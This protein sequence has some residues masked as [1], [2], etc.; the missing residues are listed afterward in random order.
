MRL[1][2][3]TTCL[4]LA[5]GATAFSATIVVNTGQYESALQAG[6]SEAQVDWRDA[7]QADDTICTEAFAATELQQY[8]RKMTGGAGDFAIVDDL[9][10]PEGDVIVVGSPDSNALM[11][12]IAPSLGVSASALKQLGPEGY[13]IK[14]AMQGG[15]RVVLIA[16]GARVG[17]LYGAY[18]FL[19]SLGVRWYAPGEVNEEVPSWRSDTFPNLDI[20]ESP[21]FLT[22]G[23]H[24]WEN[25]G[26]EQFVLWM[27]R[28]RLNYWCVQQDNKP[29]LH[30][31]G[32][33]LVGG[34]HVLTSFYLPPQGEYPYNH[35]K[36]DGD[37]AKPDDP[38]PVSPEYQGDADK[39]GKLTYFEAHPEWFGLREGKRSDRIRGDGGDNFCTSNEDAMAE[40]MKGAVDD[41]AEGRYADADIMN[42]WTLDGGRWCQCE[43]CKALGSQT[44]RNLLFVHAY[45]KAIKRAQAE[46]RINRPVRLLF[47]AYADVLQ[48]PT[49]PLPADFDY[50][51]CIATYFPI[52]RCY[53]HEFADPTCSRNRR[54]NEHLHGWA[55]AD[56]PATAA[57]MSTCMAGRSPMSATTRASFASASTTT[58]PGTSAC[59]SAT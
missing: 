8:L 7:D 35:P 20:A 24:A 25:R 48:P 26:D 47:L 10:S 4:L 44:D 34:G 22:R 18:R 13:I 36:F 54:Y 52:V 9:A 40:W 57:T 31:L 29:L 14:S 50:D 27:A 12:Q 55:V 28:N 5:L 21:Q 32:I 38:Y 15:R 45:A 1:G 11:T 23:F 16:G 33:M 2:I 30:K 39:N 51:V 17:T 58:C 37:D 49:H 42:A 43:N 6:T 19:H 46:G 59:R 41:L 53:V 56:D 3:W